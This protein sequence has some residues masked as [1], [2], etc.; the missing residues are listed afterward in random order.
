MPPSEKEDAGVKSLQSNE[1]VLEKLKHCYQLVSNYDGEA[2]DVLAGATEE[3]NTAFGAD[4]QKQI[5]RAAAQYDFD[6]I[7][8]IMKG[9]A[10]MSGLELD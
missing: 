1:Q 10:H 6:V 2:L 8:S 5:M 4:V 3:L 7:I 9:N